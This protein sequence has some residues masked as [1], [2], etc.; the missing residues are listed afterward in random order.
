MLG[1][2][3]SQNDAPGV[4]ARD[5]VSSA[6][7]AFTCSRQE[8]FS[9]FRATHGLQITNLPATSARALDR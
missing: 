6:L 5:G 3:A 8:R 4:Q 7:A 1:D 9:W 2:P